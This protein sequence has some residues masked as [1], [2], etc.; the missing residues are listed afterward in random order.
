MRII[1]GRM[2]L[3]EA[4][5]RLRE[6]EAQY[7]RAS[8]ANGTRL[9]CEEL[10]RHTCYDGAGEAAEARVARLEE[11]L[12]ESASD[13]SCMEC[14][15]Q[16]HEEVAIRLRNGAGASSRVR[17]AS[18]WR[19]SHVEFA[20]FSLWLTRR[21]HERDPPRSS[22]SPSGLGARAHKPGRFFKPKRTREY[23]ERVAWA[24][25]AFG[26]L[27]LGAAECSVSIELCAKRR[28]T[29]DP[30]NY[31]KAV[32]DGLQI[33]GMIEN[34]RQVRELHITFGPQTEDMTRVLLRVLAA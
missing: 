18:D 23:E 9:A 1:R 15:A 8:D 28:L 14:R 11:A 29:G 17:S 22:R 3:C 4:L 25:R 6:R 2:E 24:C 12:R 26:A 10:E 30:D 16:A 33:G 7:S 13:R 20:A 32:L 27:N 34:D 5:A 31:A 19:C 21:R